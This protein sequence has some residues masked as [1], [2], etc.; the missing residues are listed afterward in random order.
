M[1]FP[2]AS[3]PPARVDASAGGKPKT[4]AAKLR[5]AMASMGKRET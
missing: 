2:M 1:N 4:T 5:L 3:P